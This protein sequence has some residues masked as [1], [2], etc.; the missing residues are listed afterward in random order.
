MAPFFY[1]NTLSGLV[2]LIYVRSY[3][4]LEIVKHDMPVHFAHIVKWDIKRV[5]IV[6]YE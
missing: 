6:N 5:L 1:C 2:C 4:T 3:P